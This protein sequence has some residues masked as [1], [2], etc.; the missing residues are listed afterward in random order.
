[1]MRRMA[2]CA[3]AAAVA[4]PLFAGQVTAKYDYDGSSAAQEIR[5]ESDGVVLNRI[6]F[7]FSNEGGPGPLRKS[8]SSA[9][10]RLDNYGKAEQ[11]VGIAVVIFDEQGN[12][13]GAGS[14]GTRVGYLKVGEHDSSSIPFG[15]VYRNLS[16]ARTFT[17][18][19]ETRE[20]KAGK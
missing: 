9:D 7:K 12:I 16:K 5:L 19:L 10:I 14:G 17:V 15:Y 6:A 3:C 1:M 11:E 18:T 20:R 8:S 2:L 13:L 4:A